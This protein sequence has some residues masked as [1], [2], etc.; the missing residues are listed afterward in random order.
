M[1]PLGIPVCCRRIGQEVSGQSEQ[2]VLHFLRLELI[3]SVIE[4]VAEL[5]GL[6]TQP[7]GAGL[8][9]CAEEGTPL[10]RLLEQL[11]KS[12]ANLHT[13]SKASLAT[14]SRTSSMILSS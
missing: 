2:R 12:G 11:Q 3:A 13:S 4:L 10:A 5:P 1:R 8:A 7:E 6:R 9:T 14:R